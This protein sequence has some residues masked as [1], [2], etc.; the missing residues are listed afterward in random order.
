M[1]SDN[2]SDHTLYAFNNLKRAS[3][4]SSWDFENI[5][6]IITQDEAYPTLKNVPEKGQSTTGI[7]NK[8]VAN[9]EY[10][11]TVDNNTLTIDGITTNAKVEIY[12]VSGQLVNAGTVNGT[13]VQI[14]LPFKGFYIAR[15][16]EEGSVTS[17][18]FVNN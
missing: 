16:S 1:E 11:L 7:T 17:V 4:C 12:N 8:D 13:S 5:W 3:T 10:I 18:K 2:V 9:N 15:I 6:E 14:S